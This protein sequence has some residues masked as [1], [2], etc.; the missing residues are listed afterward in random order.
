MFDARNFRFSVDI[1]MHALI[2]AIHGLPRSAI[3]G[4][5]TM[6][7]FPTTNSSMFGQSV[8]DCALITPL[9]QS[10]TIHCLCSIHLP[11]TLCFFA[12]V[13]RLQ[14]LPVRGQLADLVC[15]ER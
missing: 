3:A 10:E 2:Y 7:K 11:M 5:L 15:Q 14:S 12:F 13:V 9:P 4:V 8:Q 1:F 6:N